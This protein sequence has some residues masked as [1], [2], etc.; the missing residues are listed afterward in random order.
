MVNIEKDRLEFEREKHL[1]ETRLA[2]ARIELEKSQ[3]G[4]FST[5]AVS[6]IGALIA[7]FSA[8]ATAVIGGVFGFLASNADNDA[9]REIKRTE[10]NGQLEIKTK[11]VEGQLKLSELDARAERERLEIEQKFEIIV[12]ATKGLPAEVASENLLFF[13][14]AGI[15]PD[16]GG[17][18]RAL[19]QQ[20]KAPDLPNSEAASVAGN[21]LLSRLE[22]AAPLTRA[23]ASDAL[24]ISDGVLLGGSELEVEHLPTPNFSSSNDARYAIM[25]FTATLGNSAKL[26]LTNPE[27]KASAHLFIE[28]SGKVIQLLPFDYAGWH[29]GRSNWGAINGLNRHSIGIVFE[30]AGRLRRVGEHWE[31]WSGHEIPDDEV[32]VATHKNETEES[33]WHTYT[34]AQTDAAAKILIAYSRVN[35]DFVDVLGHDDISPRRK[36]DPG[37]AF[38]MA[39]LR[40]AVFGRAEPLP[41]P[42]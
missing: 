28:R 6:L 12:Q 21:P 19:A 20:G 8:V 17:K 10:V 3:G 4:R 32:L 14:E 18:I 31:S 24:R 30:N 33:G 2:E 15:L 25:N 23:S 40:L 36:I 13:V 7:V 26:W 34:K 27:A 1:D 35:P 11:E 9:L 38:P 42:K 29:A 16:E 22:A 37:P 39:D 41:P 5:G